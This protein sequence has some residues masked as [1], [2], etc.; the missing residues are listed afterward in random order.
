MQKQK[1]AKRNAAKKATKQRTLNPATAAALHAFV[2]AQQYVHVAVATQIALSTFAQYKQAAKLKKQRAK[3][4][5][6]A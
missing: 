2:A 3:A 6:Q 1:T 5:A 4:K